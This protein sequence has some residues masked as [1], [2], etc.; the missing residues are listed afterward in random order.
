MA[1]ARYG[2]VMSEQQ[3]SMRRDTVTVAG[4]RFVL[5][6]GHGLDDVKEHTV[7]AARD[8][9]GLID[10][11][12]LGNAEV[13]VLITP[14]VPVVFTSEMI[15]YDDQDPRD[16]GDVTSVFDPFDGFVFSV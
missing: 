15:E 13:S 16:T 9:G 7:R 10:L 11:V 12:V 3:M 14:G 8:G 6:Q 2:R 5:A 4:E 1:G